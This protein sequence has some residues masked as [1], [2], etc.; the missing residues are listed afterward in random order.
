M[1]N[2]L[3]KLKNIFRRKKT[4]RRV[5]NDTHQPINMPNP[6]KDGDD[7]R[8]WIPFAENVYETENIKMK[9][10]GEYSNGYP[11][12]LVV[13]WD[14]G[15]NLERGLFHRLFPLPNA[16]ETLDASARKYAVRT[17]KGGQKNGYNFLVMDVLGRVYQSRPLT[18]HGYHA[19]KSSWHTVNGT[20]SNDFAG[21]E[22]KNP[23]KLKYKN[24]N[25]VTWF[26]YVIPS[27]LVRNSPG[28]ANI[29]RGDYATFSREQE[30]SLLKL[31]VWLYKNSPVVSGKKVFEIDNIVGHDE[32]SP[33]RKSDPGASLS[34]TMQEFREA[35]KSEILK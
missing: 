13:H 21:V 27:E 20:V 16:F 7:Y 22:I 32:V 25:F 29:E 15:W 1:R 11:K 35:V 31:C 23:G 19:G 26:K 6:V 2:F 9:T 18:K 34:M 5:E 14:A 17:C 30:E 3:R 10:R 24:G 28:K 33:G 4:T 8:T 12:G